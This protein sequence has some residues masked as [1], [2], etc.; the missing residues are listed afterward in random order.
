MVAPDVSRERG[1]MMRELPLGKGDYVAGGAWSMP[2]LDLDGARRRRPLVFGEV[3]LHGEVAPLFENMFSGRCS[4]PGEWAIMWKEIGADG[5]CLRVGSGDGP[6]VASISERTRLPLVISGTPEAV[7]EAATAVDDSTMILMSDTDE[8]RVP[9]HY[10]VGTDIARMHPT[11]PGN[12]LRDAIDSGTKMRMDAIHSD[13]PGI[14]A[15]CDVTEVCERDV[16]G[17]EYMRT[18]RISMLEAQSALIAMLSGADMIIVR[19]PGSA[20]MTR[21]YGEELANL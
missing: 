4:S 20:D 18:R 13:L 7:R 5:I 14:P 11:I 8:V 2:F 10:S 19:G 17:D 12:N 16:D 21:V 6:A 9:G 15:I 1:T 3:L